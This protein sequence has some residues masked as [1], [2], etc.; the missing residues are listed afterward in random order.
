MTLTGRI[1]RLARRAATMAIQR[2]ELLKKAGSFAAI[3]LINTAVDLGVFVLGY[4]VVGLPLVPANILS[5][6]VAAT[7]SY[8][9]NSVI[10][11]ASVTGRELSAAAYGK[12]L[13][14]GL[15][16]LFANTVTVVALSYVVPVLAAK[17]FAVGVSFIVNF[18]LSHLVVFRQ[19]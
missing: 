8:A 1:A 5:W 13:A 4:Q 3:G 7:G 2:A 14:S 19:R 12:F 6:T 10:T 9:M 16:G 11:F 17:L 18:S 15:V